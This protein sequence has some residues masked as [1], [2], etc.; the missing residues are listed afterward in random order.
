MLKIYF[1]SWIHARIGQ[2]INK[3]IFSIDFF[4]RFVRTFVSTTKAYYWLWPCILLPVDSILIYYL[5]FVRVWGLAT[6]EVAVASFFFVSGAWQCVWA[7][8]IIFRPLFVQCTHCA[9]TIPH[10]LPIQRMPDDERRS[11]CATRACALRPHF[12]ALL[13]CSAVRRLRVAIAFVRQKFADSVDEC[14]SINCS[15]FVFLQNNY[16]TS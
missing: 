15:V 8:G 9:L 2:T 4:F 7:Y 14:H 10:T 16:F 12:S 1:S 13:F 11:L 5:L 6:V 3:I